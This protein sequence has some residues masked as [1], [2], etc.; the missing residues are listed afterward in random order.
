MNEI[1]KKINC[2]LHLILFHAKKS[3]VFIN[4]N[5]IDFLTKSI[6]LIRFDAKFHI[7]FRHNNKK[8]YSKVPYA[9]KRGVKT[10]K[11]QVTK[12]KEEGA[13]AIS[14]F[15]VLSSKRSYVTNIKCISSNLMTANH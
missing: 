7:I 10:R 1:K 8:S 15:M 4:S 3:S 11:R 5:S 9:K 13:K 12:R 2:L 14:I 6:I